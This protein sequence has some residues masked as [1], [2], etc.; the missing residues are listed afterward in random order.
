MTVII[1]AKYLLETPL[2]RRLVSSLAKKTIV[3]I[4]VW[5]CLYSN[6]FVSVSRQALTLL[7]A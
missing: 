6:I 2:M 1:V 3:F 5:L 7:P 4:F